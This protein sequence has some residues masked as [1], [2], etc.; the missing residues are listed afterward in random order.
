MFFISWWEKY[1]IEAS[2]TELEAEMPE[3]EKQKRKT[4]RVRREKKQKRKSGKDKKGKAGRVKQEKNW[5]NGIREAAMEIIPMG[6][7]GSRNVKR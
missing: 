5:G 3:K 6:R 1:M 7:S 4:G 2:G